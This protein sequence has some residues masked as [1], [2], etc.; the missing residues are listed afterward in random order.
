MRADSD[1]AAD[2]RIT[3][4]LRTARLDVADPETRSKIVALASDLGQPRLGLNDQQYEALRTSVTDIIHG[5]WA[6]NFNLS[7]SSFENPCIASVSHLLDLTIC[8]PLRPKPRF[9][10]I[11]SIA[12]AIFAKAQGGVKEVRYGM[13]A[14]V[15]MGYG[16]SKWVAEEICTAAAKYA[17]QKGVYLPVQIFR[18]GQVVGDTKH[19]IWNP[20]EAIPLTVQTALSTGA[21]PVQDGGGVHYWL[22]V[23]TAAAAI[24][25]LAFR[26]RSDDEGGEARVFHVSNTT[27]LRWTTEFL[28]ALASNNL[29]FE[30]VPP[31]EWMRR[32]ESAVP[33]HRLLSFFKRTYGVGRDEQ[34]FKRPEGAVDM[35]EARKYSNTL[36]DVTKIDNGMVGKFLN[37]WLGLEDWRSIQKPSDTVSQ[38]RVPHVGRRDSGVGI[39]KI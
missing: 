27:P 9:T 34:A 7:L 4:S 6:V 31:Q 23:D 19:G 16:L 22:P 24:V 21:L 14:A 3:D 11:S 29:S 33:N 36:R 35:S 18:V 20:K 37:Y 2:L 26:S 8:S 15:Q 12:A 13:E 38:A 17:A 5:A 25:E 39:G 30:A 1:E 32:L 10:F 28:P